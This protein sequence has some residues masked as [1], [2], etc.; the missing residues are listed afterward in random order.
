MRP[1]EGI[2]VPL[3][4]P[5]R[6]GRID[7]E[8]AQ[9][10]ALHVADA[11]I[12]GLVVYGS[13]GEAAMLDE[14]EQSWFLSAVLEAVGTRCPVLMGINEASTQVAADKVARLDDQGIAGFLVSAP[15][16]VRPSQQGILLH[17]KAIS[18]ATGLPIVIYNIPYRTGVN[19][20]LETVK[21][22]AAGAGCIAIKEC[23]GNMNRFLELINETPL[24]VL[25]G[26]D[27]LTLVMLLAGG[28]GMLRP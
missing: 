13:T 17:F 23:G 8:A 3:V 14:Q 19:I 26:E 6:E 24:S 20:E 18:A 28:Q 15:P 9:H 27:L 7:I 11:G 12:H 21:A 2:W 5:F 16:Y 1:F 22:L 10:L 4:T 25:C